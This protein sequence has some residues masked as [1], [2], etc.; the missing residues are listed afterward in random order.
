MHAMAPLVLRCLC[1]QPVPV[2]LYQLLPTPLLHTAVT[3]TAL[4]G[5]E[6]AS[7]AFT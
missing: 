4:R 1:V 2:T 7:A 5:S 3:R 6:F